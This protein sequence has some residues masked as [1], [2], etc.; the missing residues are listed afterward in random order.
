MKHIFIINGSGGVGKDTFVNYV[1][2][3][4]KCDVVNYSSVDRIKEIAKL[5]GWDGGKTEKDRK[6]LSDLKV[7]C[8]NY[9]DLPFV[10]ISRVVK[11]F[12]NQ[13]AWILFLHIREPAEIE[14]AKREFDAKT[15]LITRKGLAP[16]TSNFADANVNN[17]DY[18]IVIKNDGDKSDLKSTAFSFLNDLEDGELKTEY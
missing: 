17:Y 13:S 2:S 16:I 10:S 8:S 4:V 14:R 7:L 11:E 18:D 1:T 5:A 9:N 6:F 12:R 3:I 15:I